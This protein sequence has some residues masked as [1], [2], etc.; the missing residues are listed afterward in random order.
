MN[1]SAFAL[2]ASA[3]LVA[4]CA[5][6]GANYTP[7]VDGT[8]NATFNSDLSACRS[9][10]K[11]ELAN[12]DAA[13][14]GAIVGAGAGAVLGGL[15]EDT[16]AGAGALVGAVTGAIAG[17]VENQEAQQAVVIK[18]MQGRGHAVVG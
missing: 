9:L 16:T 7:I 15:D 18:C 17:S 4:A 13:L 6:S 8:K 12:G 11:H 1:R 14:G 3:A 10:A 5:D 2:I